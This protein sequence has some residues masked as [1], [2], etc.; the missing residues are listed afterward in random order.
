M[1]R[2]GHRRGSADLSSFS[3][4]RSSSRFR[5]LARSGPRQAD[6][7]SLSCSAPALA[8]PAC[9]GGLPESR[10]GRPRR[11]ARPGSCD[12]GYRPTG[13][14]RRRGRPCRYLDRGSTST[15]RAFRGWVDPGESD[16]LVFSAALVVILLVQATGNWCLG[17]HFNSK[18]TGTPPL[19]VASGERPNIYVILADGLGRA[20]VLATGYGLDS[21]VRRR[22]R[23]RIDVARESRTN[24]MM[25][26]LVLAR[27]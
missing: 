7:H 20:D 14:G 5:P 23:E 4:R 25:T 18:P 10:P 9:G 16:R 12:R 13:A 1:A 8:C 6:V 21:T 24:Y 3:P 11:I 2:P 26:Q 27:C 17:R 15:S 19:P 22:A